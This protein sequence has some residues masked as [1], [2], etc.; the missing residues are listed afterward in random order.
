LKFLLIS[1]NFTPELTGIGKYNGEMASYLVAQGHQVNVITGYPYYPQWKVHYGYKNNRFSSESI[2]GVSVTR[3]PLYVPKNPSGFKRI[4]QD[5]SFFISSFIITT[6][7]IFQRKKYDLVFAVSPSFMNGLTALWYRLFFPQSKIIY[8]LQDLQIDAAQ[9]LD[10]IKNKYFLSILS[11]LETF[12]LNRV[13]LVSTITESMRQK[14]L[15]KKAIPK[16][17]IVFPNWTDIHEL[18]D[19]LLDNTILQRLNI[20]K[21]KK[22]VFYSGALGEKQGLEILLDVAQM[23]IYE[24]SDVLFLIAAAGPYTEKLHKRALELS[25]KNIQFINLLPKEEFYL[26]LKVATIHLVI[27]KRSASDLVMPSKLA[28][29]LGVGGLALVSTDQGSD[30]HRLI[31]KHNIAIPFEPENSISLFELIKKIINKSEDLKSIKHTIY[32]EMYNFQNPNLNIFYLDINFIKNNGLN[33][34][35]RYL[36]RKQLINNFILEVKKI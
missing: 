22:I 1:Y 14:I 32:H 24:L 2:D 6:S 4:L 36:E 33:Y 25:L 34:T 13:D 9:N 21:D 18:S 23:S 20:P 35:K 5:F 27:Q 31:L 28:T 3:C 17:T 30:L 16:S 10:I 29:I 7:Q 15:S 19:E 26:L 11:S 12:I 8:H